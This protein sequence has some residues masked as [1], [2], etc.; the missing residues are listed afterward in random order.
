MI[1]GGH[2]CNNYGRNYFSLSLYNFKFRFPAVTLPNTN[3]MKWLLKDALVVSI[4]TF[5]VTV[6][7]GRVIAQELE[8]KI[9]SNQVS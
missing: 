2:I 4:I 6:S 5:S 1:L 7:V 8:Y 9:D 3:L